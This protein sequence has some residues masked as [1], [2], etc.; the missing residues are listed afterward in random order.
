MNTLAL[1]Y[2]ANAKEQYR[3]YVYSGEYEGVRYQNDVV[4]LVG[5]NPAPSPV[6]KSSTPAGLPG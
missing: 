6:D 4:L 5:S 3:E 1:P 2:G